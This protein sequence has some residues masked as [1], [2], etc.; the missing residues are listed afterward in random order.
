M[1]P[2]AAVTSTLKDLFDYMELLLLIQRLEDQIEVPGH[3]DDLH[4]ARRLVLQRMRR[5]QAILLAVPENSD[6]YY[7][8][9]SKSANTTA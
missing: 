3:H 2:V 5:A 7:A 9:T 8:D 1:T 6:L 4:A